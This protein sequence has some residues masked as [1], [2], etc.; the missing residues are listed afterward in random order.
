MFDNIHFLTIRTEAMSN[1]TAEAGLRGAP[2]SYIATEE[3]RSRRLKKCRENGE[4]RFYAPVELDCFRIP[5][6]SL[7]T[8][9]NLFYMSA[10]DIFRCDEHFFTARNPQ[11]VYQVFYTYR[12]GGR[13]EY[14]GKTYHLRKGDGFVIDCRE[15][16]LYA[17]ADKTWEF[18][19]FQ[20]GGPGMPFFFENFMTDSNPT[21]HQ[22][23]DGPVQADLER[24][25][26]LYSEAFPHRDWVV[27]YHIL[28]MLTSVLSS[29]KASSCPSISTPDSIRTLLY[30]INENYME[31]LTL[32]DL[33]RR[34]AIS[35]S[36][37]SR[38][39][40][41]YTGD[42]PKD[43]IIRLRLDQAKYKLLG[44]NHSVAQIGREVGFSDVNNFINMFKK[45][46]GMTP[47]RFRKEN[48]LPKYKSK[49]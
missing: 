30:Y 19:N 29:P 39:F 31:P 26:A 2:F 36:H 9:E 25:L 49:P 20:I 27:S 14:R 38:L 6:L 35:R 23:L 17:S 13:L 45:H 44:T 41:K 32:E 47:G 11:N 1:E 15:P 42:A 3:E 7:E 22:E 8:R 16:Y 21:F 18:A 10:F 48:A 28:H 33:S 4:V 24:I 37:M 43:Y 46:I 5:P 12:G 40:R 34:F